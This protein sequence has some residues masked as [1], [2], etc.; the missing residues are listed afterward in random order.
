M[1]G[2]E[3]RA[4]ENEVVLPSRGWHMSQRRIAVRNPKSAYMQPAVLYC[5]V[6]LAASPS[7]I[8]LLTPVPPGNSAGPPEV[9]RPS[10]VPCQS[11]NTSVPM[12]EMGNAFALKCRLD[13]THLWPSS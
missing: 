9:T 13:F 11:A 10:S 8:G 1:A 12:G 7:L 4:T 6:S 2:V 3:R 5:G